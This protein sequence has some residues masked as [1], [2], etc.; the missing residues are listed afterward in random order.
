MFNIRCFENV[1][2]IALVDMQD[3]NASRRGKP[4]MFWALKHPTCVVE[5]LARGAD[6][7]I[8]CH[9][10]DEL[11]VSPLYALTHGLRMPR[12]PGRANMV[13]KMLLYFG[14]RA[15]RFSDYCVIDI[16]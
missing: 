7:N 4:L 8:R 13:K 16:K 12:E 5:L 9:I 14:G 2:V 3:P 11:C 1:N 6:P 10:N 15:V